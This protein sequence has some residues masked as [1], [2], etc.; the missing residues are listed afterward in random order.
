M[1]VID[2]IILVLIGVGVIQGLMKGMLKQLLQIAGLVAGLLLARALFG[3][4]A[5]KLAPALGTSITIA[6]ILSFILIWVAVPV[7]CSLIASVLTKAMDV[8][9]LGWLNR[10]LGALLG[11]AKVML[12]IGLAIYKD[13]GYDL[14]GTRFHRRRGV[15]DLRADPGI[16]GAQGAL[17]CQQQNGMP[18]KDAPRAGRCF[19]H[20]RL[21]RQ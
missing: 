12:L 6:Q 21:L 3:V 18:G 10:L 5:E 7:A 11:A 16:G 14:C 13:F 4:V 19:F 20:H 17:R 9:N 8:I 15:R 1:E 2:I